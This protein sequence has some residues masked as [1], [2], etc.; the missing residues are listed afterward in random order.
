MGADH[1]VF[2][3]VHLKQ[4]DGI[5]ER[6]AGHDHF[7]LALQVAYHCAEHIDMRRI[8]KVEPD[9]HF[10]PLGFYRE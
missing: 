3:S 6:P 9:F 1:G 2:Q 10:W 8:G 5:G 7:M 4:F